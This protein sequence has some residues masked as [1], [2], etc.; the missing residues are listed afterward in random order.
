MV[1]ILKIALHILRLNPVLFLKRA[2]LEFRAL[3]LFPGHQATKSLNGV[4]FTFDFAKDPN[5]RRMYTGLYEMGVIHTMKTFLQKGDTFIDVGANIGYISAVAAGFIGITGEIH[6]FE[7]VSS[8][9]Q[10]LRSLAETNA[11]YTIV[12]NQFA[13]GEGEKEAEMYVANKNIGNNTMLSDLLEEGQIET[14]IIVSVRRLDTYIK[15]KR[16]KRVKMIKIDVEGFE[17]PVLKGLENFFREERQLPFIICEICPDVCVLLGYKLE[18][19]FAYME[20]FSYFPF[21]VVNPRERLAINAI[22]KEHTINVLF[23]PIKEMI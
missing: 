19:L 17:F 14:K 10:K 1:R 22:R 3:F 5:I 20:R 11:R 23:K 12:A 15:D 18:D 2:F 9:F 7:P 4:L 8:Y 21:E 6:S 16:L 13:L